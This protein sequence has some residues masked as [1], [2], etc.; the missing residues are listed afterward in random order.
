MQWGSETDFAIGI[1]WGIRPE[2]RRG[3]REAR[4]DQCRVWD[5]EGA[6]GCRDTEVA[7]EGRLSVC[8]HWELRDHTWISHLGKL[9]IVR[10]Y[11]RP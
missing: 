5:N 1:D 10:K 2:C 7:R 6:G 3:E 8:L 9:S 11:I 4:A